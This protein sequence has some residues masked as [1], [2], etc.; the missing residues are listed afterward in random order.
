MTADVLDKVFRI[1]ENYKSKGTSGESGTGLGLILCKEYIEMNG[2]NIKIISDP[3][4]GST[5]TLELP[6]GMDQLT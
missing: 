3:E 6:L 2:G 5:F 1:E 4:K